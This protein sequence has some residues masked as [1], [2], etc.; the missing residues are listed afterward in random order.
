MVAT[1][2]AFYGLS[3]VDLL[4][5]IDSEQEQRIAAR[6]QHD[7]EL[8]R[9]VV[10]MLAEGELAVYSLEQFKSLYHYSLFYRH[11]FNRGR[12]EW[13]RLYGEDVFRQ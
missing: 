1:D 8:L 2:Q 6:A 7:Y 5:L 13:R 3:D 11:R 12:R 10:P 4:L 9:R